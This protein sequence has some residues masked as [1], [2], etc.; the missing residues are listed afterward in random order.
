M[1]F[2]MKVVVFATEILTYSPTKLVHGLNYSEG[3]FAFKS[4]PNYVFRVNFL[5]GP[6]FIVH[7]DLLFHTH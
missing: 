2:E 7:A 4:V 5:G 6:L 1:P 3:K